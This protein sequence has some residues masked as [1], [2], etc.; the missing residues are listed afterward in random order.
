MN[1]DERTQTEVEMRQTIA[2]L[3]CKLREALST[4]DAMNAKM[5][6]LKNMSTLA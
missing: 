5:E 6:A 3:E 1:L 4:I 2:T